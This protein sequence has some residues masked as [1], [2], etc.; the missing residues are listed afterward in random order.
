MSTSTDGEISYG[1]LFEE[2]TEFPWDAEQFEGDIDNW[3]VEGVH[4]FKHSFEM[5][6]ERGNWLP[7]FEKDKAARDRYYGEKREFEK[8]LPKLPVELVNVCHADYPQYVLALRGTVKTANRGYPVKFNPAELVVTEEQRA[9]LL[10]FCA[11]YGLAPEE[12][13]AWY[14][15]SYWG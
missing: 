5:F 6:D 10:D 2:G 1:V 4:G 11:K 15:S 14:L 9:A 13:P 3:W 7:G 8:A 12:E